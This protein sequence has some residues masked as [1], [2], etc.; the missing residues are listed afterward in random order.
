M[1]HVWSAA[2]ICR[3]P[4]HIINGLFAVGNSGKEA[5]TKLSQR[6]IL[7]ARP[8][9]ANV[10][11]VTN[12]QMPDRGNLDEIILR[13]GEEWKMGTTYFSVY[14]YSLKVPEVLEG[15]QGLPPLFIDPPAPLGGKSGILFPTLCV[16]AMGGRHFS[17]ISQA[18]HRQL[19]NVGSV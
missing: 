3:F 16:T 12:P 6:F 1:V 11:R 5:G 15:L 9:N 8:V 4:P 19:W 2:E 7:D 17:T 13:K 14:F 18:M 10:E